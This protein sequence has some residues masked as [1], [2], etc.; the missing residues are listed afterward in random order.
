MIP[1][2]VDP[3]ERRA[4]PRIPSNLAA[5]VVLPS[6]AE[7]S[8][9]I[10]NF[11]VGGM[12]LV[13]EGK[14]ESEC[15]LMAGV[16]RS[17]RSISIG[18]DATLGSAPLHLCVEAR[19]AHVYETAIGVAFVNPAPDFLE[20]MR[21]LAEQLQAGGFGQGPVAGTESGSV[22]RVTGTL[23]DL[24]EISHDLW[25]QRGEEL[26]HSVIGN[27]AQ[28][29]AQHMERQH[30]S[31]AEALA[32]RDI[33]TL[34]TLLGRGDL[35]EVARHTVYEQLANLGDHGHEQAPRR[36]DE[37]SLVDTAELEGWL[38]VEAFASRIETSNIEGLEILSRQLAP[39]LDPGSAF[40][41][42][43]GMLADVLRELLDTLDPDPMDRKRLLAALSRHMATAM[44]PL[45]AEFSRRLEALGFPIPPPASPGPSQGARIQAGSDRAAAH[46]QASP[47]EGLP[48][49]GGGGQSAGSGRPG[50]GAGPMGPPDTSAL[51]QALSR[52]QQD[53]ARP[54]YG[55]VTSARSLKE[56]VLS[57][58]GHENETE[59]G[60]LL[61][62]RVHEQIDTTDRLVGYLS[63]DAA[64]GQRARQW[65]TRLKIPILKAALSNSDFFQ[66]P[67]HPTHR[68]VNQL[69]HL[70][71]LIGSARTDAERASM[72]TIE[73]LIER[74]LGAP[75]RDQNVPVAVSTALGRLEEEHSR[76]YQRRVQR[77][78]ATSVGNQRITDA[79][80][81]VHRELLRRFNGR[82]IH[83]LLTALL[84]DGWV[85]WMELIHIEQG[86]GSADW[87]QGWQVVDRL[88]T[89]LAEAPTQAPAEP[90]DSDALLEQVAAGLERASF[91]PVQRGQLLEG[92]SAALA[93][94][95]Q[96]SA[97]AQAAD[98]V[99]YRAAPRAST[100]ADDQ[101]P[102]RP[103]DI[104][105]ESWAR[106]LDRARALQVGDPLRIKDKKGLFHAL[107]IAW[108]S[109][110]GG[111]FMLVDQGGRKTRELRLGQLVRAIA[112]NMATAATEPGK[113]LLDRASTA[114]LQEMGAGL[115]Y[116]ATHDPLTG[117]Y[118]RRH[119]LRT[120]D[121]ILDGA[122]AT[123]LAYALCLVD[124]DQFKII[125][126]SCGYQ[127]G[128][129]LL[130]VVADQLRT[131]FQDAGTVAH[132]GADEFVVFLAL[133]DPDAL[134]IVGEQ[135]HAS[136]KDIS[137]AWGATHFPIDA[138]VGLVK[139]QGNYQNAAAVLKAADSACL[140]A[141]KGGR[142]RI[143][144]YRDDDTEIAQQRQVMDWVV[145]VNEAL[146]HDRL[147]LR[148]Q[149][150][151]PVDPTAGHRGHYEVLLG[152]NDEGGQPMVLEDFIRAAENY[153]RMGMVDRW[154]I[155]RALSWVGRDPLLARNGYAINLSGHSLNDEGLVDYVR[156]QFEDSGVSPEHISFEVTE[157]VAIAN[158]E[159]AASVIESIKSLGCAFALDDFGS[160]LS[161]YSYLRNLPVDL[162]KIDGA[163]VRNIVDNPYDYAVVKSINEIGHFM[164]KQTIAEYVEN[165]QILDC[166]REIGV[167]YAQGY[168][169][170]K[171]RLLEELAN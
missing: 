31:V 139:I 72:L 89:L 14:T 69:D 122:R 130:R 154:V 33:A 115:A 50:A 148:C 90:V 162:V 67:Q 60:R 42:G 59:V 47:G 164:G 156:Q 49:H 12:L 86:P 40:P 19:V 7:M 124:L 51:F 103:G 41:L 166:L 43:P 118:N 13:M 55:A 44:Q 109:P 68:I 121:D 119:L 163:F 111:R 22:P 91:D 1:N 38:A 141:K 52:L 77:L 61:G 98:Y 116:H 157:T 80:A 99:W 34:E 143:H 36:W 132:M 58:L 112:R 105:E 45:Y 150:I 160:G 4:Y 97:G 16:F 92:L 165:E 144:T 62:G 21:S 9:R 96:G 170:E 85:A 76:D 135:V 79:Q 6:G 134:D 102:V 142:N 82:R 74:L 159:K 17:N 30:D 37:L 23:E 137:F 131:R 63:E 70:G 147:V 56:E 18:F 46:R 2:A 3:A 153:N 71:Q 78:V 101:P 29:L 149:R 117:L 151:A 155:A 108:V 113:P 120:V 125:N 107:R 161:S 83:R 110:G 167:D 138:S 129:Q 171:P 100:L 66:D 25:G 53:H 48:A 11:C 93:S 75:D 84:D 87:E 57:A 15:R 128:D 168:G 95:A 28:A 65:L 26:L 88:D 104:D 114:M 123:A 136:I 10:R 146:E 81:A 27:A 24:I 64:V 127:A 169:V 39:V 8:C 145:R 158:L 73:R 20:S 94:T 5:V 32:F 152:V 106:A 140:A 126:N 54:N 133:D 35:G